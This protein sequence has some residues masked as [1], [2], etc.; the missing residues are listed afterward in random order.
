MDGR[1]ERATRAQKV[2]DF[3]RSLSKLGLQLACGEL[4]VILCAPATCS[5]LHKENIFSGRVHIVFYA[6]GTRAAGAAIERVSAWPAERVR[7]MDGSDERA[8][9]EV[10][11]SCNNSVPERVNTLRC[12][13]YPV[14]GHK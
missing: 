9:L 8:R 12:S 3:S 2:S 10:L 1:D 4:D 6:T 14:P 11:L 7:A 5:S 13:Y